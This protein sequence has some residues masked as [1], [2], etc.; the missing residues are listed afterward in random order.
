VVN[1]LDKVLEKIK[2]HIL[3]SVTFFKEKH[4][5]CE[6][7]WKNIVERSRPQMKIWRM[8][9]ACWIPKAK[10]RHSDYVIL[11]TF[12]L[13]SVVARTRLNMHSLSRFRMAK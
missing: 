4:A 10:N 11:I 13:A 9:I 5:V 6:L 2:K 12:P 8:R 3:C 7:M 1:V